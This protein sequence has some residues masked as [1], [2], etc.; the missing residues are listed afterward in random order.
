MKKS[1]FACFLLLICLAGCAIDPPTYY[2]DADK[3]LDHATE[4]LLVQC[5][6]DA[7][8]EIQIGK[9]SVPTFD[10]DDAVVIAELDK[11]M[12]EDFIRELSTITF[13]IGNRSVDSPTGYAV[14]IY[15]EN[16]EVI[17]L[18]CTVVNGKAFSMAA[19]FTADGKFLEHIACFADQPAFEKLLEKFFFAN[20]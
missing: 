14:L 9:E 11:P 18:S 6:N 3:L 17:V 16:Q 15:L 19:S 13:H 4:I 2:F 7:P 5:R 10:V 1:I 8:Q 20:R 12:Y